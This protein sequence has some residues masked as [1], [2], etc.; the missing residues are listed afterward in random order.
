ML[1]SNILGILLS[2]AYVFIIIGLST[3][4]QKRGLSDEGSRKLVHIG[5]SNWW[6]IAALCFTNVLWAAVVP[7]VFIVLNAISYRKDLF[8]SMERHEGAADLGTVYYPISLL[9]LTILCFGGFSLPYIGALGVFVM[10]YGDGLAAVVGKRFGKMQ[11]TV[12]G[13]TKSFLG[14]LTMFLV[15]FVV[16]AIILYI[17]TPLFMGTVFLQALILSLIATIVEALTP[18]GLDNLTVPLLT[19]LVYQ[20][21]F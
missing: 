3:L 5:V 20:F 14:S 2:F 12:F 19:F 18:L 6:I 1:Y 17:V 21:L 4:L 16:C 11:Y 8:K 9:I 13:N 15:S 10:G 7:A